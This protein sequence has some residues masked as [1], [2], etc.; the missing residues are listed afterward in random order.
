MMRDEEEASFLSLSLS[1][2]RRYAGEGAVLDY[3]LT[4][5]HGDSLRVLVAAALSLCMQLVTCCPS[6]G[7]RP[8]RRE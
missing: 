2:D 5:V 6:H 4:P 8:A 7:R 3:H 1:A